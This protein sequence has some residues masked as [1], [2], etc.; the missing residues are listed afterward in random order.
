MDQSKAQQLLHAKQDLAPAF[1]QGIFLIVMTLDS[2]K[3]I[4]RVT[5]LFQFRKEPLCAFFSEGGGISVK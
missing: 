1:D 4:N 3:K 2:K 5:K